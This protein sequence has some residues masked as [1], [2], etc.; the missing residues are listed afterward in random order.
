MRTLGPDH[1]PVFLLHP[2][3]VRP[4][5]W[6]TLVTDADA[7]LKD[8]KVLGDQWQS[9]L[10]LSHSEWCENSCHRHTQSY[11]V[12]KGGAGRGGEGAVFVEARQI[13]EQFPKSI[14]GKFT[15]NVTHEHQRQRAEP[16]SHSHHPFA[17]FFFPSSSPCS[18]IS[19]HPPLLSPSSG[20][21]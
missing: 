1:A 19:L 14:C 5:C 21:V 12:V 11:S 9:G 18:S 13:A 6:L 7:G 8:L 2:P 10:A 3:T 4:V 16:P 20:G 17:A 15:R